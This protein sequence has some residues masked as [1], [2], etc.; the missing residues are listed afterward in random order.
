MPA[1]RQRIYWDSNVL[2]SYVDGDDDRLPVLDE[3]FRQSRAGEIQ[4]LTSTLSQVEVA[5]APSEKAAAVLDPD[6]EARIDELWLPGSPIALVEF[7]SA[8]GRDARQ[9]MRRAVAARR[10]GPRSADAIHLATAQRMGA[11]D[12]HTYDERL[13]KH[14]VD[15]QFPIREPFTAQG[16]LP[17]TS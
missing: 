10:S 1:E 3:L 2:L 17:G 15:V 6:I 14:A 4:L 11:V 5:F 12:F 9:L 16:R 8:L 7:H 13:K